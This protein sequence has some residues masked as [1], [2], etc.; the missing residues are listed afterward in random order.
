VTCRQA[1]CF[2][3]RENHGLSDPLLPLPAISHPSFPGKEQEGAFI[4]GSSF[5]L[6]A[7]HILQEINSQEQTGADTTFRAH[8]NF[9]QDYYLFFDPANLL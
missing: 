2:E 9:A 4:K 7:T 3:L 8:M 6:K 5:S 1:E